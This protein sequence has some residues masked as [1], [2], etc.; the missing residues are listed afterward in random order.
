M[1]RPPST[2]GRGW[3]PLDSLVTVIDARA[4]LA[5]CLEALREREPH[6]P[7]AHIEEVAREIV[8]CVQREGDAAVVEYTQRFDCPTFE[9]DQLLVPP[10]D[11]E[12]TYDE[13]PTAWLGAFRRARENVRSYH[14][15]QLPRSWL[16]SFDGLLLG[17][18][19]RPGPSA[20]IHIPGFS[21]PL[22]ATVHMS[23]EPARAAGVERVAIAT[24]PRKDGSVDPFI[25]VAAGECRVDDIYRMGGAQ[26]IA[27]LACGTETVEP[28]VRSYRVTA[29][30]SKMVRVPSSSSMYL[31]I[32]FMLV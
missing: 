14:E 6:R 11:I 4:G 25:L 13:V 28:V 16:E 21:A 10:E 24:P 31:R 1:K 2:D 7:P 8:Q 23:V 19:V 22:F 15:R 32:M 27:A 30:C 17:E 12:A 29:C 5:V 26:A 3:R 20:G 18:M 9:A